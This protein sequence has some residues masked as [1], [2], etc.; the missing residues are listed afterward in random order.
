MDHACKL[1]TFEG[2]RALASCSADCSA[3][4]VG[5][6]DA[7]LSV[8][9]RPT[10]ENAPALPPQ[11]ALQRAAA[12]AATCKRMP[13]LGHAQIASVVRFESGTRAA[14]AVQVELRAVRP[15]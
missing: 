9:R 5:S 1:G 8:G 12:R 7:G 3:S 2:R 11:L 15:Q 10:E 14:D 4:C 13:A 6:P